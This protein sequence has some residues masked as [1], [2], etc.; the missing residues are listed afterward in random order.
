MLLTI[1]ETAH[2]YGSPF[3]T[4][5]TFVRFHHSKWQHIKGFS[6]ISYVK[7]KVPKVGNVQHFLS[8]KTMFSFS[9]KNRSGLRCNT[10]ALKKKKKNTENVKFPWNM[11]Q[12][13][14]ILVYSEWVLKQMF[15]HKFLKNQAKY[16]QFVLVKST[17]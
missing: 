5:G 17:D 6:Y 8:N 10:G 12:E 3:L 7:F 2:M 11:E 1:D 4:I 16:L 15:C 9:T 14:R 13:Y